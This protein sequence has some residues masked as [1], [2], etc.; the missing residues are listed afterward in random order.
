M[1]KKDCIYTWDSSFQVSFENC[2]GSGPIPVPLW[3][4]LADG[5]VIIAPG[6]LLCCMLKLHV[7]I[8]CPPK[9]LVVSIGKAGEGS[10]VF[11]I[12]LSEGC[13]EVKGSLP[14]LLK[15]FTM[16]LASLYVCK[17][18]NSTPFLLLR[19]DFPHGRAYE[20]IISFWGWLSAKLLSKI[21]TCHFF[22]T[23]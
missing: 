16:H 20:A 5:F 1:N 23:V 4:W 11:L 2:E 12:L 14:L 21:I 17:L 22:K 18:P 6:V 9:K 10:T 8:P 3:A 15:L 19:K 13:Q 7:V